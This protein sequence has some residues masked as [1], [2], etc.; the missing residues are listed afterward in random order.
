MK[1]SNKISSFILFLLVVLCA[2]TIIGLTQ[3]SKIG[4]ELQD[5]VKQ[6]MVL[7]EFIMLIEKH[8]FQKAILF[9]RVIRVGEEIGFEQM[10]VARK[11]YLLNHLNWI[12]Q[13][14]EKLQSEVQSDIE[15]GMEIIHK[16][17][18]AD[19]SSEEKQGLNEVM[20]LL[21]EVDLIHAEYCDVTQAFF[22]LVNTGDHKIS[23]EDIEKV[24]V[25]EKHLNKKLG[26]IIDEVKGFAKASL[27][28]AEREESIARRILWVSFAISLLISVII[29]Y[30]IIRSILKP[31]KILVKAAHQI[32]GGN[33]VVNLDDATHDE[34]GEVSRAINAMA[35]KLAEVNAELE[36]KNQSL[37]ESL[38]VTQKQ[39]IDLEKVNKELDR[40]VHTVS[41]DIKAPLTGII[42]YGNY[43][44]KQYQDTFDD[45]GARSVKGII[46]QAER[47]N[48][49]INDLLALT[50]ISRVKNPYEKASIKKLVRSV[51]ERLEFSIQKNQ[52]KVHVAA[53]LPTIVCDRIKLSEVFLNLLSNAIKF[54]VKDN[55]APEVRIGYK[56]QQ[57]A[58]E[59]YVQDNGIGIAPE[60][61]SKVFDMFKRL[62]SATHYE[63][64]GAGLAIVKEVINDHGGRIWVESE[65]GQGTAFHF[66]IPKHIAVTSVEG[67]AADP[68]G[69]ETPEE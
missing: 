19:P 59:F 24:E 64:T 11:R 45:R 63:G 9:E 37:S 67:Q 47:L 2:N 61:Q 10:T 66:T 65:L 6:D 21:K 7:T 3:L 29:A 60:D 52:V 28:R 35:E 55:N 33:F 57:D 48:Q 68:S 8:Q 15:K 43:L 41:H 50:R 42:G 46:R 54:S 38:D 44:D 16:G 31:L 56:D 22:D 27:T 39:K 69:G 25:A 13:G 26:T 4:R 18:A 30:A 14:F 49:L 62:D 51:L 20:V 32:G 17:L 58:Y 40:F 23:F 5:V 53:D 1:I 12:R 34:I 36:H